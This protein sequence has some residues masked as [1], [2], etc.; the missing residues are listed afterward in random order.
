[1]L[2]RRR[3][4]PKRKCDKEWMRSERMKLRRRGEVGFYGIG[5]HRVAVVWG[6]RC[7]GGGG[8]LLPKLNFDLTSWHWLPLRFCDTIKRP[9]LLAQKFTED[10]NDEMDVQS[11]KTCEISR[12]KLP[13]SGNSNRVSARLGFWCDEICTL[14]QTPLCIGVRSVKNPRRRKCKCYSSLSL[15]VHNDLLSLAASAAHR[16]ESLRSPP[17]SPPAAARPSTKTKDN[18]HPQL[19]SPK[20]GRNTTSVRSVKVQAY[21]VWVRRK[22]R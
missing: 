9:M 20:Y 5:S 7:G 8:S 15:L 19:F 14:A 4:G 10:S 21:A 1:M 11:S 2:K 3:C 13:V 12:T 17:M 16:G 18:E 22:G 6:G